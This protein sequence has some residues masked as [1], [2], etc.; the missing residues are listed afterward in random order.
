MNF[1]GFKNKI[2]CIDWRVQ[3]HNNELCIVNCVCF[4]VVHAEFFPDIKWPQILT[5]YGQLDALRWDENCFVW[6]NKFKNVQRCAPSTHITR[7]IKTVQ[8][9]FLISI[10]NR[11]LSWFWLP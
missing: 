10:K 11:V 5:K 8:L 6:F 9:D 7:Y 2:Y 3:Q 1:N 4:I